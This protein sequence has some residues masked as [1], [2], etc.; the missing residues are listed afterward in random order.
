MKKFLFTFLI[1]AIASTVVL[2]QADKVT[3]YRQPT[4]NRTDIVF[5]YAGDPGKYLERAAAEF[6]LPAT[7]VL[8]P[9]Q[10]FRQMVTG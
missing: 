3:L 10:Y 9:V 2:A 7:S 4:M 6:A 8:K 1:L 5:V